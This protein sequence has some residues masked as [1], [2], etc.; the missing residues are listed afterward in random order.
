[1]SDATDEHTSLEADRDGH[2][3]PVDGT[4]GCVEIWEQLSAGRE[5]NREDAPE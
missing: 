1:M 3:A 5:E 4:V 2:L